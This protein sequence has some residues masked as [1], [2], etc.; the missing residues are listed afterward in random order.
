MSASAKRAVPIQQHTLPFRY[1]MYVRQR[2][3]LCAVA[4]TAIPRKL[5]ARVPATASAVVRIVPT[6]YYENTLA[7]ITARP[8]ICT[9]KRCLPRYKVRRIKFLPDSR[10]CMFYI[11]AFNIYEYIFIRVIDLIFVFHLHNWSASL[12]LN[13]RQC[14]ACTDSLDKLWYVPYI[15]STVY[16]K[17]YV[18]FVQ[19]PRL[20]LIKSA[21][22]IRRAGGATAPAASSLCESYAQHSEHNTNEQHNYGISRNMRADRDILSSRCMPLLHG[23]GSAIAVFACL[24]EPYFVRASPVAVAAGS[25]TSRQNFRHKAYHLEQTF[26]INLYPIIRMLLLHLF[27]ATSLLRRI[28]TAET[29]HAYIYIYCTVYIDTLRNELRCRKIIGLTLDLQPAVFRR[30]RGGEKKVYDFLYSSLRVST[31]HGGE[32]HLT[33]L[34]RT[35]KYIKPL[36][37]AGRSRRAGRPKLNYI[38]TLRGWKF[39]VAYLSCT[40]LHESRRSVIFAKRKKRKKN[41]GNP[42]IH[43]RYIFR[44]C[45]TRQDLS[46]SCVYTQ[47]TLLAIRFVYL[48]VSHLGTWGQRLGLAVTQ[49]QDFSCI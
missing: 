11:F 39:T 45:G 25:S 27:V 43:T 18:T 30:S 36:P 23:E 17:F 12:I 37:G 3:Q 7:T 40:N 46:A 16:R 14:N 44:A 29:L 49:H 22:L 42:P 33:H 41:L 9:L 28:F 10:A 48:R 47:H 4:P 26:G 1:S 2:Q 34:A 8:Y 19:S 24:T 5:A 31:P 21:I 20:A 6:R 13:A 35:L 38:S 15:M 32:Y